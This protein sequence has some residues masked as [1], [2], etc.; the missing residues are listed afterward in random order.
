MFSQDTDYRYDIDVNA[1]WLLGSPLEPAVSVTVDGR[2]G[3]LWKVNITR[4]PEADSWRTHTG[5]ANATAGGDFRWFAPGVSVVNPE[6][7]APHRMVRTGKTLDMPAVFDA[8]VNRT[9]AVACDSV[10]SCGNVVLNTPPSEAWAVW[11]A[12]NS[13]ATPL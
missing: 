11:Y 1:T 9:E 10:A 8:L 6:G 13:E 2:T 4:W 5:Q 12:W 3:R 7:A